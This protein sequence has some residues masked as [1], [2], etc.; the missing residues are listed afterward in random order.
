M[1]QKKRNFND[2]VSHEEKV[3]RIE[4]FMANLYEKGGGR[5]TLKEI[6]DSCGIVNNGHSGNAVMD[7]CER[8][9]KWTIIHHIEIGI[10]SRVRYE[11]EVLK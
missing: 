6:C 11:L 2:R 7:V 8:Y 3:A 1:R 9:S 10:G 4:K 5:V